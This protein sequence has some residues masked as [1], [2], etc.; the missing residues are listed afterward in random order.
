MIKT[1]NEPKAVVLNKA[2]LAKYHK[3]FEK[4]THASGSDKPHYL[5]IGE[6]GLT[7]Y[8]EFNIWEGVPIT[9]IELGRIATLNILEPKQAKK[10]YLSHLND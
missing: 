9:D 1:I 10:L 4:V 5:L 7:I 2:Q 3:A 8:S 6:K